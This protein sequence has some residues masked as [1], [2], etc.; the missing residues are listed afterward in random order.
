ME[1]AVNTAISLQVPQDVPEK[2]SDWHL[3]RKGSDLC[4][5]VTHH[6]LE[7]YQMPYSLKDSY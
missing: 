4:F 1:G 5:L 7:V 6:K 2:L 3:L